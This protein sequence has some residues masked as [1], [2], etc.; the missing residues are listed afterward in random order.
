VAELDPL[1]ASLI[2]RSPIEGVHALGLTAHAV[3]TLAED[4][5]A[6]GWCDG[7]SFLD[8]GTI[9]YVRS[10]NSRREHFTI[11]H[12]IAHWLVDHDDDAID[13]LADLPD[14]E[15]TLEQ[16]CDQ[17]AGR[18]LITDATLNDV[19]S[20]RPIE[21]ADVR[22]LY[23]RTSA[24]EPACAIA[25]TRRLRV[26]GAVVMV[27]RS[28]FT[29]SYASLI[30]DNDDSRPIAY[31]WN[32]QQVPAG[33]PLRNLAPRAHSQQRS[34]WAT[35][36]GERQTYYLDAISGQNRIAAVFA[37]AD[38]WGTER[39]HLDEFSRRPDRPS[40]PV[41][42]ICGYEGEVRTYPHDDCGQPFCPRCG[43][44]GCERKFAN[45][46][47]CTRCGV[48]TTPNDLVGGVCSMCR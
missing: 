17:V 12:E 20:D 25:L 30:W 38:L 37:E 28:T 33:H 3:E 19:T 47:K 8:D 29:V 48:T 40:I 45:H 22:R 27:E 9:V 34:W 11:A 24:S 14:A 35:K 21:A 36:W 26:P 43:N 42:C 5:G 41:D 16:L 13:W 10:P 31:P 2:E 39:L 44:C 7:M 18:L 1:T 6:N 32:G 23:E 46:R 15:R 4:R